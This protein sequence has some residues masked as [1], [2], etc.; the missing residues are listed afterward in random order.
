MNTTLEQQLR[1]LKLS[2]FSAALKEQQEMPHSYTDLP[3]EQRLTFL[4]DREYLL[5]HNNRMSRMQKEASLKITTASLEELDYSNPRR[6]LGIKKD[7]LLELAQG[8]WIKNASNI[9]ITG[10]TGVGKSFIGCALGNQF[11]RLDIPVRYFRT[12]LLMQTLLM[13]QADGSLERV[14][15]K[16]SS[17]YKLLIID[18]WLREPASDAHARL[19][20]D[21][22]DDRY[23]NTST[24]F[25]SQF[26]VE[27]WYQKFTDPTLAEAILDRVIHNAHRIEMDGDSVRKTNP[28]LMPISNHCV[29]S[30]PV[31]QNTKPA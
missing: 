22:L 30:A 23:K 3:F 18:E 2:G 5:R 28:N 29:A 17:A 12:S 7:A 20:L 1:G 9:I 6:R 16:L 25:I 4:I 27:S 15:K 11:L 14:L 26:P 31:K 8:Q 10:P 24:I 21:L 19:L 13:A